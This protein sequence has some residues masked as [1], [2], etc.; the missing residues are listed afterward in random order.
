L[1]T[2]AGVCEVK[3]R[4]AKKADAIK[5]LAHDLAIIDDNGVFGAVHPIEIQKIPLSADGTLI[6]ILG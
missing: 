3:P 6:Y 1:R 5:S 2:T 4:L